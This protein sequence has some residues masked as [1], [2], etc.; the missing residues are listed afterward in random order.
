MRYPRGPSWVT[1][2]MAE[3]RAAAAT[4]A[5]VAYQG[6]LNTHGDGATQ[7]RVVSAG[8]LTREGGQRGLRRADQEIARRAV[9]R[10]G[11]A[12]PL[13]VGAIGA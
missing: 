5:S 9:G 2:A 6:W 7:C 3:S 1:V 13:A 11:S 12:R 4:A 8:Q 10:G